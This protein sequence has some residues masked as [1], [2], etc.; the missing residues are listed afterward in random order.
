MPLDPMSFGENK[1][2]FAAFLDSAA[3]ETYD[4]TRRRLDDRRSR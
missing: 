2:T 4:A 1:E 3:G